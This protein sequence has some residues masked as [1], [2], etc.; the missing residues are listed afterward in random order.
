MAYT[1]LQE[2]TKIRAS[3]LNANF[4]ALRGEL[5][6]IGAG[7]QADVSTQM[8][9]AT[10]TMS[11][12][13]TQMTDTINNCVKLSGTQTI[14]GNKTF[15]GHTYV[16]PENLAG[17]ALCN[18]LTK[19]ETDPKPRGRMLLGNRVLFQWGYQ[20]SQGLNQNTAINFPKN[21]HSKEDYC[22]IMTGKRSG[23]G[24]YCPVVTTY[25]TGGVIVKGD[26][27]TIYWFAIGKG[28][29]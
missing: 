9:S 15:T 17:T 12:Q 22:F 2:N 24:D 19:I 16:N 4:D 29:L 13:I 3:V 21:Y 8:T 10:S 23:M 1:D 14:T 5:Q 11:T 20:T 18:F 28:D 27:G 26:T 6:Q 7:I 25:N